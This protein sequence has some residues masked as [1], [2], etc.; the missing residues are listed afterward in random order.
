MNA[1]LKVLEILVDRF[2]YLTKLLLWIYM[3]ALCL[4]AQGCMLFA[5]TSA[6]GA[7]LSGHDH[8]PQKTAN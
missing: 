5:T 8:I 6:C 3:T 2:Q 4:V 1:Q 7:E